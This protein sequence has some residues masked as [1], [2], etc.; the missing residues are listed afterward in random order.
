MTQY[1]KSNI[2]VLYKYKY[3][4]TVNVSMISI[5][6]YLLINIILLSNIKK[7]ISQVNKYLPNNGFV[8]YMH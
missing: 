6:I 8:Y 1:V 3:T 4:D 5:S 2:A 7:N